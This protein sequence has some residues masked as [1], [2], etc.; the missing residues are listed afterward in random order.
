MAKKNI[1]SGLLWNA[2]MACVITAGI[3]AA[4]HAWIY[5]I[6]NKKNQFYSVDEG[7]QDFVIDS[8]AA[9]VDS[10]AA[11]VDIAAIE[12]Y[13]RRDDD[14]SKNKTASLSSG[15]SKYIANSLKTGATPYAKYYGGNKKC[16]KDGCSE[17]KV[18]TSSS[19]VL[20]TIKKNDKVVR[21]AYIKAGDSFT[22]SFPNG[23]YQT[24]FYYGSGWDPE[25]KMKG[26]AINGGFISNESF[27]KDEPKTLLNN[28]LLYSLIMQTNGN[29]TTRP[30]DSNEAL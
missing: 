28:V 27:G 24:F 23:T 22:F 6:N 14:A 1:Y 20:V 30:S 12:A 13:Q 3:F 5:Q 7:N 21:H 26:G 15:N 18:T 25:K 29:F 19:D 17:I 11:I 4:V 10:A 9:V 2:I 16:S 8:A